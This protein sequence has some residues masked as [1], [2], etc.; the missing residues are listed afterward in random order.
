MLPHVQKMISV[1]RECLFYIYLFPTQ[2]FSGNES[3]PSTQLASRP[4]SWFTEMTKSDILYFCSLFCIIVACIVAPQRSVVV[5]QNYHQLK[6]ISVRP[7]LVEI[8]P[9]ILSQLNWRKALVD[10]YGLFKGEFIQQMAVRFFSPTMEW[11]VHVFT[12]ISTKFYE[13]LSWIPSLN[14]EI[15]QCHWNACNSTRTEH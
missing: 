6:N 12:F 4:T 7:F 1:V 13:S 5:I 2:T 8:Q 14:S 11:Y 15:Q 9:R 3:L 10:A